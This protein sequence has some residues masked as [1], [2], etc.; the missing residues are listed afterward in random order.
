MALASCPGLASVAEI[1][2]AFATN[3]PLPSPMTARE[4]RSSA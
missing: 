1:A 2:V 3:A 4:T